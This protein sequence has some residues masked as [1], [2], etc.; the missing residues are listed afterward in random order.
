MANLVGQEEMAKRSE[1]EDVEKELENVSSESET[2]IFSEFYREYAL[3]YAPEVLMK[4]RAEKEAWF[5]N[6]FKV[7]IFCIFFC[8]IRYLD[9]VLFH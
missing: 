7:T 3:E 9:C 6:A 5:V 1:G 4:T 2:S 8:S